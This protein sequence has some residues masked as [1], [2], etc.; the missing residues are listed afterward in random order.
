MRAPSTELILV[1]PVS[2][3]ILGQFIIGKAVNDAAWPW[4]DSL[5]KIRTDSCFIDPII[6][7]FLMN[8]D[9]S[10][11]PGILFGCFGIFFFGSNQIEK[12]KSLVP[13]GQTVL[14]QRY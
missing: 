6:S 13:F 1:S 3:L 9:T 10:F 7:E 14:G 11:L 8:Y 5:I 4:P 12:E 2:C